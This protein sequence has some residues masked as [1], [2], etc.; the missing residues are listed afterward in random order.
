MFEIVKMTHVCQYWRSTLI[1]YPRLWSSIFVKNDHRDFVAACLE[2]NREAPLTVNLDLVHGDYEHCPDR[3]YTGNEWSS[4]MW[5]DERNLCRYPTAL[6]P[7]LKIHHTR[8]IRTLD[9]HLVMLDNVMR[10][11]LNGEFKDALGGFGLF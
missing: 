10:N 4:G 9:F 8:R 11:D 6:Y 3:T 1:S 7:L 2:R 5:V